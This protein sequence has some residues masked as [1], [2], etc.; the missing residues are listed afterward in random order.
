MTSAISHGQ[1]VF[2]CTHAHSPIVAV[3]TSLEKTCTVALTSHSGDWVAQN[4]KKLTWNI[5]LKSWL[6]LQTRNPQ[7]CTKE[8]NI[9]LDFEGTNKIGLLFH[10]LEGGTPPPWIIGAKLMILHSVQVAACIMNKKFRNVSFAPACKIFCRHQSCWY[11][12]TFAVNTAVSN[13]SIPSLK[14]RPFSY[15]ILTVIHTFFIPN[16]D[17]S[18]QN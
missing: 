16:Y 2:V 8:K 7:S 13:A 3:A 12:T 10:V 6:I 9:C 4:L 18:E 5:W 11:V 1:W 14:I 17:I 15:Q